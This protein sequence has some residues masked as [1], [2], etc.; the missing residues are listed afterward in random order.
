VHTLE[1]LLN[2]IPL[3]QAMPQDQRELIAGCASNVVFEAGDH[4]CRQGAPADEFWVIREGRVALD[5][6]VPGRGT[7]TVQTQGANDVV[8]WS[9]L[10]PPYEWHFDVRALTRVRALKFDALCIRNKCTLNAALGY[11]LMVRFSQ[12]I[13]QRL[14]ATQLQ[15][16]DVYGDHE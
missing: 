16:L 1:V 7:I 3:F 5:V 14:E 11:D 9:W 4:L 6:H 2:E 15:L 13:V 12:L 8:G 10:L